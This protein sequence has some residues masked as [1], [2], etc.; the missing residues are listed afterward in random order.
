MST[1]YNFKRS[2]I[3]NPATTLEGWIVPYGLGFFLDYA[4]QSTLTERWTYIVPTTVSYIG[5][6]H[7]LLTATVNATNVVFQ[8]N[9]ASPSLTGSTFVQ[10][11]V[12]DASPLP[13]NDVSYWD[14]AI[15]GGVSITVNQNKVLEFTQFSLTEQLIKVENVTQSVVYDITDPT[16]LN[17]ATLP[18]W[19]TIN[20]IPFFAIQA[21]GINLI[22]GDVLEF[23]IANAEFPNCPFIQTITVTIIP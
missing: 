8:E 4:I 20:S 7:D 9:V 17:V 10:Y 6:T 13:G 1:L 14:N 16:Y 23:T 5:N 15:T 2:P 22:N 21:D 19:N 3:L 12:Q 18:T 11:K